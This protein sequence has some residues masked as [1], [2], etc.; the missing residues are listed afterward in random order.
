MTAVPLL[1][2]GVD[3]PTSCCPKETAL[4]VILDGYTAFASGILLALYT[5]Q[6]AGPRR[7]EACHTLHACVPRSRGRVTLERGRTSPLVQRRLVV[8]GGNEARSIALSPTVR[9]HGEL[10]HNVG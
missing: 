7:T 9:Q 8:L 6:L 2:P 10:M 1:F 4:P 5:G 3:I